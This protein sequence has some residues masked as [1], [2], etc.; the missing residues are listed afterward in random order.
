[1][2]HH[3]IHIGEKQHIL[4]YFQKLALGGALENTCGKTGA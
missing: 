3:I 2:Y 1:M 4:L